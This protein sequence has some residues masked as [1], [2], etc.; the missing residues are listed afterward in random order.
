MKLAERKNIKYSNQCNT[1]KDALA[2]AQM[3]DIAQ[4][5]DV[6]Y[7]KI[8]ADRAS[9]GNWFAARGFNIYEDTTQKHRPTASIIYSTTQP[10]ADNVTITLNNLFPDEHITITNN[11]GSDTYTFT[12]NGEFTFTFVN[13]EG[14]EGSTTEI[15]R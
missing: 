4:P 13:D 1:I 10:T 11:G 2:N 15:C 8:V 5:Q 3:F 14:V 6:L 7:I 9:N 12:Q